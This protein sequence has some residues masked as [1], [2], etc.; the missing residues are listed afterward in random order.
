LAQT[1]KKENL[2]GLNLFSIKRILTEKALDIMEYYE[3]NNLEHLNQWYAIFS[4]ELSSEYAPLLKSQLR[5]DNRYE[6]HLEWAKK[7]PIQHI[8][9]EF[10][11]KFH[12]VM[13]G[14]QMLDSNHQAP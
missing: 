11:I 12:T 14:L 3:V 5:R 7:M 9:S 8:K 1:F 2:S 10:I 13:N 6:Y 4:S